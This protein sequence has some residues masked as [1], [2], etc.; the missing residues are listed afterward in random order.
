MDEQRRKFKV[1]TLELP[2]TDVRQH[3]WQKAFTTFVPAILP[4]LF[5]RLLLLIMTDI[6]W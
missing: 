3:L 1:L 2:P 4:L 6:C 5:L